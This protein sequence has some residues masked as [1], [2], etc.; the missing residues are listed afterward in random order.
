VGAAPGGLFWHGGASIRCWGASWHQD[1]STDDDDAFRPCENGAVGLGCCSS[2]VAGSTAGGYE[3]GGLHI[4]PLDL[5]SR[6]AAGAGF[7]ARSAGASSSLD[8]E[9]TYG[10]VLLGSSAPSPS[11]VL[12]LHP[13]Q[14]RRRP[15]GK[16]PRLLRRRRS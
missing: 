2:C 11:T 15:R 13:A 10:D 1:V 4:A 5:G 14:A 12:P 7:G 3:A 8:S 16:H 6:A 9:A